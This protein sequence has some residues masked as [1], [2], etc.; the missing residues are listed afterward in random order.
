M[1]ITVYTDGAS[2]GNPGRGGWGASIISAEGKVFELGGR[3][4]ETTN[5]RMEMSAVRGA[6]SF[7][8]ERKLT[9]DIVIHTDSA[10]VLN[11][12]TMWMYGWE[13]NNWK[14]KTGEPVLNQ[15]I[16]QVLL[17]LMFR[18]K[19]TH[20]V[21]LVKV[22]G[23]SGIVGNERV[24]TIATAYADGVPTVLF[25][26]SEADYVKMMGGAVKDKKAEGARPA[27]LAV[28]KSASS[29]KA[30]AYVSLVDGEFFSDKT[31]EDCKVRVTGVGG[32]KYK[33]VFSA[34]ELSAV[35]KE[36]SS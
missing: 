27:K 19:K 31:W 15:D 1:S 18:L 23:H 3:E 6:L 12:I 5:N 2:R 8:E 25:T 36:W 10:Y 16:W 34:E 20:R 33:K 22:K 28:R 26:G 9:G 30:F 11:G 21:E 35:Q 7:I 24:D 32:V 4:A 14:T 13:K 29:K 17:A